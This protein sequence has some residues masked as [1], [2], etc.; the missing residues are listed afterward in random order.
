MKGCFR[1]KYDR[2][3]VRHFLIERGANLRGFE[4]ISIQ[5]ITVLDA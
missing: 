1:V 3:N 4:N 2:Q 5:E